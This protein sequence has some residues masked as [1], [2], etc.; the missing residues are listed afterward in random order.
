[1]FRPGHVD[2]HDLEALA[3]RGH[4]QLTQ[5]SG[6]P[7]VVIRLGEGY[8]ERTPETV[9]AVAGARD[10]S[11]LPRPTEGTNL[12][13][14]G[15]SQTTRTRGEGVFVRPG[16]SSRLAAVRKW[17]SHALTED[18]PAIDPPRP[19]GTVTPAE[20]AAQAVFRKNTRISKAPTLDARA[21]GQGGSRP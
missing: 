16:Y 3:A 7:G 9:T 5:Q 12:T 11:R 15:V 13:G 10:I 8:K 4:A 19:A 2:Q 6:R 20:K 17:R 18:S 21:R 1:V 14:R